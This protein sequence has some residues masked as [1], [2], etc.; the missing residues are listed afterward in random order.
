[1]LDA[2]EI[3]EILAQRQADAAALAND[4]ARSVESYA[5]WKGRIVK[6]DAAYNGESIIR[7][8]DMPEYSTDLHIPNIVQLAAEDRARAASGIVPTLRCDREGDRD[9]DKTAAELRERI[10]VGYLTQSHIAK[11]LQAWGLDSGLTG[12]TVCKVMPNFHETDEKERFPAFHRENPRFCYPSPNYSQGPFIDDIIIGYEIHL[13]ELISRYPDRESEVRSMLSDSRRTNPNASVEKVNLVE[14]YSADTISVICVPAQAKGAS[15]GLVSL[16]HEANPISR[17]PVTIGT[18]MATAE[19]HGDFDWLLP[20]ISTANTLVTMQVDESIRSTYAEKIAYNVRNPQDSGP[21]AVLELETRDGRYEYVVPP[22]RYANQQDIRMMVDFLRT[23]AAFSPS[24]SGNPDESV[25]SAAGIQAAQGQNTEIVGA[26]QQ[27]MATM[28]QAAVEIAYEWDEK[29]CDCE[30]TIYGQTKGATFAETYTPSKAIKGNYR[31]RIVYPLGSG[32]T[33]VNQNAMVLQQAGSGFISRETAMELSAF[34]E[35][36]QAEIKR[37]AMEKLDDATLS[38]LIRDASLPVEQG[39]LDP[40]QLAAIRMEL[41]S[42]NVSLHDA[43]LKYLLPEQNA[44]LAA[45]PGIEAGAPGPSGMPGQV[46]PESALPPLS[47]L[48]GG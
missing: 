15:G 32:M 31:N 35:N 20:G 10:G 8:P 2:Q 46:E 48:V 37:I 38:G 7:W 14:F 29:A 39:G 43:I 13:R 47:A 18:R 42:P 16:Y 4:Y 17:C 33:A 30:K 45:P 36:P 11:S 44:P 28:L 40:T 12:L 5:T 9:K 23:G 41:E 6:T 26:I 1:M 19:Y 25:I 22:A 34:V 27:T 24:R 21:D 3:S